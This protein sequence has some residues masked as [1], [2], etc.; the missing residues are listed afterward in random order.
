MIERL[1]GELCPSVSLV[2]RHHLAQEEVFTTILAREI[3]Q[4]LKPEFY[5]SNFRDGSRMR[6]SYFM[7]FS[8]DKTPQM[9]SLQGRK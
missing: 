1:V 5:E 3:N 8:A 7:L 6:V 4:L 9:W 2:V